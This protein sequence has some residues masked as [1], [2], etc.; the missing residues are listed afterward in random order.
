MELKPEITKKKKMQKKIKC[1]EIRAQFQITPRSKK[2][3]GK[4]HVGRQ[5]SDK[6]RRGKESRTADACIGS[7]GQLG[8][9]ASLWLLAGGL[10]SLSGLMTLWLA[11]PRVGDPRCFQGD[12][13]K[14]KMSSLTGSRTPAPSSK[15]APL[16][17]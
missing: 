3:Q 10:S 9:A 17:N 16:Q 11:S 13:A 12:L 14:N 8:P 2:S 4:V 5:G 15:F 6:G 7:S 1:Q